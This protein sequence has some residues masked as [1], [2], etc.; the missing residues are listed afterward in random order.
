MTDTLIL[1]PIRFNCFSMTKSRHGNAFHITELLCGVFP[2]QM[3]RNFD[4]FFA[5]RLKKL[6]NKKSISQWVDTQWCSCYITIT[7]LNTILKASRIINLV[8]EEFDKNGTIR[9]G[10]GALPGVNRGGRLGQVLRPCTARQRASYYSQPLSGSRGTAVW[11][12]I[13]FATFTSK[14]QPLCIYIY[15]IKTKITN[16]KGFG[17]LITCS[18]HR[19]LYICQSNLDY[20][21]LVKWRRWTSIVPNGK[22]P[23]YFLV[24]SQHF[25]S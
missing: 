17:Y 25:G 19:S 15:K 9:S 1:F 6:L 14:S 22:R 18:N 10:V 4:V 13:I 23:I 7:L 12:L 8:S 20:V 5:V 24:I 11:Q 16:R 21:G 3:S 2:A